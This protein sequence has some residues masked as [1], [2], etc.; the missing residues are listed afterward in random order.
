MTV[1]IIHGNA[2]ALPLPGL[3]ACTMTDDQ[4]CILTH[5]ADPERPRLAA[6]GLLV[7]P[8][9]A[10]RITTR[11]LDLPRLHAALASAMTTTW[12][13]TTTDATWALAIPEKPLPLH[14][15]VAEH[16]ALIVEVLRSLARLVAEDHDS[17]WPP[18][19]LDAVTTWLY[20]RIPTVLSSDWAPLFA[21]QI[22]TLTTTAYAYL[23]PR[24]VRRLPC[25]PCP[26]HGIGPDP[27]EATPYQCGGTL[28]ARIGD[29]PADSADPTCDACGHVVPID[30]TAAL[31]RGMTELLTTR[32]VADATGVPSGTVGYWASIGKLK[33]QGTDPQGR[34]LYY[35]EHVRALAGS[36]P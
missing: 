1:R 17:T 28:I 9:C 15:D 26:L 20:D 18:T 13:E 34:T 14:P 2:L 32:E 23:E 25:G 30:H 6:D 7:C 12:R 10:H 8:G 4:L 19:S 29:D 3:G 33:R 36:T 5:R 22:D 27:D 11:L 24:R 35:L 21:E 31:R 16:R